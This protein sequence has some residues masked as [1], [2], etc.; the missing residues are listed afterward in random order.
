MKSALKI[1]PW[2]AVVLLAILLLLSRDQSPD[3]AGTVINRTA[4]LQEIESLGKIELVRYNFKEITEITEISETYFNLFKLGPD[5]KIALISTGEAVGCI[6]LTRL[7]EN[8]IREEQDTIYIRLPPPE[9]CYYKLDMDNTRIYSL[10]TN[11]MK[12]EKKFIQA[13]YEQAEDEIRQSALNSGI[14]DD[15]KSNAILMLAPIFEEVS[16][17]PVVLSFR[18]QAYLQDQNN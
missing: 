11:F 10:E 18:M 5:Q 16:G 9:I 14:L 17:K 13:A 15:T 1:I 8:D 7:T 6:D 4:I 2:I 3:K 12:D